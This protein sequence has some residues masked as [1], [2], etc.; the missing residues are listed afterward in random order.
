MGFRLRGCHDNR[1]HLV[2]SQSGRWWG[3]RD[4]TAT[5]PYTPNVSLPTEIDLSNGYGNGRTETQ[6]LGQ[7]SSR[8]TT[9]FARCCEAGYCQ[10]GALTEPQE[11]SIPV[12]QKRHL[13]ATR[14]Y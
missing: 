8:L 7:Q 11:L 6:G 13:A 12:S 9:R 10:N 3:C 5:G 14:L 1:R 4:G 2:V